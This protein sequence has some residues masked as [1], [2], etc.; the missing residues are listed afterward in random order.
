M[1]IRYVAAAALAA[2][3]SVAAFVNVDAFARDGVRSSSASGARLQ[4]RLAGNAFNNLVPSGNADYR[5]E[6]SGRRRLKVEAE[7][8]NLPAGT[9][10]A[11]FAGSTQ[12]GT[13]TLSGLPLNTGEMEL[14]SQQGQTVPT[15]PAGTMIAVMQFGNATPIVTGILR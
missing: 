14:E 13:L 3:L 2:V 4:A 10:L 5:V 11:V 12:V 9:V 15:L 7:D 1:K 8:V 6:T